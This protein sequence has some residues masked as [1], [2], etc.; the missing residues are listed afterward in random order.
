MRTA[1][2]VLLTGVGV[3]VGAAAVATRLP[4]RQDG[5]VVFLAAILPWLW[6]LA[7][8]C[9]G[10]AALLRSRP[11]TAILAIVALA[12]G[13]LYAPLFLPQPGVQTAGK[14]ALRVMSFSAWAT[15]REVSADRIAAMIQQQRPDV[16]ALQEIDVRSL[17]AIVAA[18]ERPAPAEVWRV[19]ADFTI[20]QAVLSRHDLEPLASEYEHTR[21]QRVR[22]RT[23]GGPV[24][25]WNIHAFRP[26]F[27][28]SGLRFLAYAGG[29]VPQPQTRGQIDWL[30]AQARAHATPLIVLGD[31]NVTYRSPDHDLLSQVLQDAHWQAGWGF[32][33]SFPASDA[34]ARQV[35]L[36]GRTLT[37]GS[38]LRLVKIDHIFASQDFLVVSARTLDDS[39]GSDHAPV[40]ADLAWGPS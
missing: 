26:D 2:L 4:L 35:G 6:V 33:L 14:P 28:Q 17:G 9:L 32:G 31:F 27:A 15:V 36:F 37:L 40:V 23:P 34:H 7:L 8:A 18:L 20:D 12:V 16:V 11:V 30:V 29:R 21:L 13:A 24:D 3:G 22:V 38:P 1:T 5:V 19:A 39:A 10:L 25:V